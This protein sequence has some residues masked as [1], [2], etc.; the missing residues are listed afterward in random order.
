AS[1]VQACLLP[2]HDAGVAGE[3]AL[4][5]EG[6]AQVRVGLDEGASDPVAHRS[7]LP[8]RPAAANANADVVGALEAG[9]LERREHQR[10]MRGAG[11]VLLDG[12]TV[13]PGRAVARPQDHARDRGLALARAEVLSDLCHVCQ[14]SRV[15]GAWASCGWSGPAYN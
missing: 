9:D 6:D 10:A 1:L 7:R 3:E 8:T 15:L 14:I 11:E 2:F 4:A 12:T 13:E 5:L